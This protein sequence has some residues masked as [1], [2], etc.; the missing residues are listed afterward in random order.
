MEPWKIEKRDPKHFA[1]TLGNLPL[2]RE[3]GD[4]EVL[5]HNLEA[6]QPDVGGPAAGKEYKDNPQQTAIEMEAKAADVITEMLN[7]HE[8]LMPAIIPEIAIV[9]FVQYEGKQIFK[10]TLV[11]QLNGNPFLSKDQLTRVQN[12]IYFNNLEEY[13]AAANSMDTCIL[14]LGSNC[15]VY[16]VQR[17][18][19]TW[20]R[21]SKAVG[22]RHGGASFSGL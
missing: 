8:E 15:V 16:M 18:S 19:T 1:Y 4:C 7:A 13:L 2:P 3:D 9:P 5:C 6:N 17:S 14:G 21:V 11:S 12:S 10:N 22:W 20:S